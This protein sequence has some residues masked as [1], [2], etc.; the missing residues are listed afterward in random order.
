MIQVGGG[1]RGN[2]YAYQSVS[3]TQDAAVLWPAL[4]HEVRTLLGAEPAPPTPEEEDQAM[5]AL[6]K[7]GKAM[8]V[9]DVSRA[10][11]LA[12]DRTGA[13]LQA[14]ADRRQIG[15]TDPPGGP[16]YSVWF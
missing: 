4:E 10:S 8:G 12:E 5:A 7:S 3:V 14:L 1:V 15:R 9:A 16:V 11:G 13:A 6:L 2:P